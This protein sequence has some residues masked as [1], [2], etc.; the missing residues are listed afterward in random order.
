MRNR[1]FFSLL[2]ATLAAASPGC[3]QGQREVVVTRDQVGRSW[4]LAVNSATVVCRGDDGIELKLGPKRYALD[5]VALS[6]GLPDAKG[7]AAE[8]PVDPQRPEFG[9]WPGDVFQLSSVCETVA[10]LD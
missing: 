5:E 7:V 6:R 9:T 1:F 3:S 2:L 4:P 8:V 10:A